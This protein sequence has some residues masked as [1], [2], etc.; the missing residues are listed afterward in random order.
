MILDDL[1][2]GKMLWNIKAPLSARIHRLRELKEELTA[3]HDAAVDSKDVSEIDVG[4]LLGA[5]NLI[6]GLLSGCEAVDRSR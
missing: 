5:L 4:V 6:D 3:A 2:C 1:L